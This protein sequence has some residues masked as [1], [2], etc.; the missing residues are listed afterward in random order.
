MTTLFAIG[1]LWFWLLLVAAFICILWALEDDEYPGTKATVVTLVTLGLIY[2]LGGRSALN[3]LFSF[4]AHNPLVILMV[5]VVYLIAGTVWSVVKWYFFVLNARDKYR[6]RI[7][8]IKEEFD[9]NIDRINKYITKVESGEE[10]VKDRDAVILKYRDEI[11]NRTNS[12]T[13]DIA[14]AKRQN[15]PSAKDNK[16]RILTWMFYWPF[17]GI[18]TIINDPVRRAFQWIYKRLEG[19]YQKITV[20]AFEGE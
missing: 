8:E 11:K 1:T 4:V 16:S 3:D 5:F 10:K 14:R 13:E 17:S 7:A 6:D 19:V 15:M 20:S 9:N 12:N 18:W 2:F